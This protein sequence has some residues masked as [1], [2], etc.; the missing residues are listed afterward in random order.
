MFKAIP[1][2]HS[3]RIPGGMSGSFRNWVFFSKKYNKVIPGVEFQKEHKFSRRIFGAISGVVLEGINRKFH[4]K[5]PGQI[6]EE[7]YLRIS[8]GNFAK[9]K[10]KGVCE[11]FS[12]NIVAEVSGE[13]LNFFVAIEAFLTK[14]SKRFLVDASEEIHKHIVK[15]VLKESM[16]QFCVNFWG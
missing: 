14:F 3:E 15:D 5:I 7:V 4:E 10:S 11:R 16:V 1:L 12:E 9:Q 8:E 6:Y 2:E 13:I